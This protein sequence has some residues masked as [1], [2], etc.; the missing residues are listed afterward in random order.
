MDIERARNYHKAQ[1]VTLD[2]ERDGQT[3]QLNLLIRLD[4]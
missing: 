2:F 1:A 4:M 3:Y